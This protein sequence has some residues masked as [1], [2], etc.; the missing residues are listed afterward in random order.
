[1]CRVRSFLAAC[2][3][4]VMVLAAGLGA[5]ARA[6]AGMMDAAAVAA[7]SEHCAEMAGHGSEAPAPEPSKKAAC[8]AAC[9]LGVVVPADLTAP[10]VDAPPVIAV[11]EVASA[12][13]HAPPSAELT[14]LDPP[15]RTHV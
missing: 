3:A 13:T 5:Q 14:A 12:P 11:V 4:L 7:V 6:C 10:R 2:L 9:A 1:M 15:P 8:Q